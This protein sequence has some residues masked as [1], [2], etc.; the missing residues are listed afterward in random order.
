MNPLLAAMMQAMQAQQPQAQRNP[1]VGR[2]HLARAMLGRKGPEGRKNASLAALKPYGE[3]DVSDQR[4]GGPNAPQG[5]FQSDA[6]QVDA[7]Q[8]DGVV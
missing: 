3:I 8:V 2:G 5:A 7:F 1:H 4:N 6:F